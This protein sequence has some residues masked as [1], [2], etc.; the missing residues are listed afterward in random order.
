MVIPMAYNVFAWIWWMQLRQDRL[1]QEDN[2]VWFRLYSENRRRA[3]KFTVLKRI[4]GGKITVCPD[5]TAGTIP[6]I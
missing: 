2:L 1:K 5:S 6:N 4:H 3:G